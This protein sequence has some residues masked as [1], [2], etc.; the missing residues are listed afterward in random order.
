LEWI[1]LSAKSKRKVLLDGVTKGNLREINKTSRIIFEIMAKGESHRLET[2]SGILES[3]GWS[4]ESD[5][6]R[7]SV[8][9]NALSE[10]EE[11]RSVHETIQRVKYLL[12]AGGVDYEMRILSEDKLKEA[13]RVY[14]AKIGLVG[15]QMV[16]KTSLARRYVIDQ[17]NDEYIRTLGAKVSKREVYLTF[18][19]DKAIR[20]D[21]AVWDI[22]GER[23]LAVEHME[24]YFQGVQGVMAVIDITRRETLTGIEDWV[25]SVYDVTGE[26]PIHLLV[27]KVD[28][29]NRFKMEHGDVAN[30][31]SRVKC[32]F[33]F[34]SAKTG[35]NVETAFTDMAKKLVALSVESSLKAPALVAQSAA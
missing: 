12:K 3:D 8:P 31:S 28:L 19:E 20:V 4:P 27:N 24:K 17:F 18:D 11:T 2:I 6:L 5:R 32:P 15:D 14:K 34:T 30:L 26:V 16:G 33:M 1:E 35:K 10:P 25:S 22:I 23:R 9:K 7:L 13:E 21:M 29:E